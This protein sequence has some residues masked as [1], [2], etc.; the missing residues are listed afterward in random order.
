[1]FEHLFEKQERFH[2]VNALYMSSFFRWQLNK[3]TNT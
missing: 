1:M 3:Q 2:D